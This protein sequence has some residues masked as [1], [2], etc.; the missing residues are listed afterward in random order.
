M[1]YFKYILAGSIAVVILLFVYLIDEIYSITLEDAKKNHQQ[2]QL[3][4]V[5]VV[6]EGVGFFLEHLI[7]D[8][9]L[10]TSSQKIKLN[11]NILLNDFIDHFRTNYDTTIILSIVLI[12]SSKKVLYTSGR[13]PPG[14]THSK[15]PELVSRF[16]Q[17]NLE[18]R[19]LLSQVLPDNP[20]D[21][22]SI[23]SFLVIFPI[24]ISNSK[25]GNPAWYVGYL[26][27][28][29]SLVKNFIAPLNLR[30]NDFVW[31][32]DG[33]GR[34]IYHPRHNEMLFKSIYE[35]KDKCLR[36]HKSFD[37]QIKIVNSNIPSFG[38]YWVQGNEPSKI[39]AY[40]PL[41][42]E[43]QK[44]YI[45]ISTLLPDVTN[46]LKD[47]FNMFFM[48]GV[49]ILFT[50]LGFVFIIYYLN[51]KRV[52]SDE[53]RKNLEKIQE[54]QEQLNHTA[55]LASIGELVDSVAHE[56]NTPLGII[57]AHADSILL[58]RNQNDFIRDE[59]EIIKKQTKRGSEYTKSLL[60]FS[61][62]ITFNVEKLNVVELINES[63]FLLE[64]KFRGK[65]IKIVKEFSGFDYYICGD[66]RQ[67]EQVLINV[68]NNAIDSIDSQGIIS[69][70]LNK[71]FLVNENV[72]NSKPLPF[73]ELEISD[74]GCGIE[75]ENIKTIFDPF[76]STKDK[77]GTG[78]GLSITKSIIQRHKGKIEV[79]SKKGEWTTFKIFIPVN[80]F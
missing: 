8:M 41:V 23:K 63:I 36:C 46:K 80:L 75:E 42:L 12:D 19:F 34:L 6:S 29:N 2:Q 3:E 77:N 30:S 11:Q 58:Q 4:M 27:N 35:M 32:L 56:I 73:V 26:V 5:K 55:R 31:I 40:V 70:K 25:S 44:W 28:F 74:N 50:M 57:S 16:N 18:K 21:T 37:D 65:K 49:I 54:Y 76:Y 61:K 15:I 64:P 53:A 14:W 39:F 68:F 10:L 62:R 45:A 38:E 79:T 78:L 72:N 20:E 24:K 7:K 13:E 52:K 43:N 33:D 48:L 69:L 51:L 71:K 1:K 9:E 66:R 47:K 59:L 67:L 60:N 22:V 17:L